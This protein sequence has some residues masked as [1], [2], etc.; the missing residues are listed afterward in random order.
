MSLAATSCIT[1]TPVPRRIQGLDKISVAIVIWKTDNHGISR[2]LVSII[3]SYHSAKDFLGPDRYVPQHHSNRQSVGSCA[4][5]PVCIWHAK[6]QP[7]WL[8][9]SWTCGSTDGASQSQRKVY[10]QYS[11]GGSKAVFFNLFTPADRWYDKYFLTSLELRHCITKIKNLNPV[12]VHY[13]WTT[14]KKT[15]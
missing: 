9:T 2:P 8:P 5:P 11:I 10:W 1:I 7:W 4:L 12:K 14:F 6:D 13:V 3:R 15:G